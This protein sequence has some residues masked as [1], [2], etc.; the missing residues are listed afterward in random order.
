MCC[1]LS[2]SELE[3]R[4]QRAAITPGRECQA[5]VRG[6]RLWT[7]VLRWR[8]ASKKKLWREDSHAGLSA[9]GLTA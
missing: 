7:T 1:L 6:I 5:A 8:A 9:K 3:R 2:Y 4:A